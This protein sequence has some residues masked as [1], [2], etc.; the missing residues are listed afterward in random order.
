MFRTQYR[1]KSMRPLILQLSHTL[2]IHNNST[3]IPSASLT[4]FRPEKLTK[5]KDRKCYIYSFCWILSLIFFLSEF[6][7]QNYY[8]N[9]LEFRSQKKLALPIISLKIIYSIV[10]FE[11]QVG[12]VCLKGCINTITQKSRLTPKKQHNKTDAIFSIY[13]RNGIIP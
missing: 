5:T 1:S 10:Y 12:W 2:W 3:T 8:P 4:K 11:Y 9:S 13:G 6:F 7:F